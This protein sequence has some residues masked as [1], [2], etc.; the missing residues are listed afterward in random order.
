MKTMKVFTK[1]AV[2]ALSIA[3]VFAMTM[4]VL[5]AQA[6]MNWGSWV[7]VP[8]TGD[9]VADT[10]DVNGTTVSAVYNRALKASDSNYNSSAYSCAAFVG[11][12]YKVLGVSVYNLWTTSSVPLVSGVG[13]FYA[14]D[15]PNVGDIVRFNNSVHW[16]IVKYVSGTKATVIQQNAWGGN[17]T[18]AAVGAYVYAGD[19]DVTFFR[20]TTAPP[21]PV[22]QITP[23]DVRSTTEAYIEALLETGMNLSNAGYEL[24]LGGQDPV[25]R[26]EDANGAYV[27][28]IYYTLTGLQ[29]A[30]PYTYRL[31]VTTTDG[32]TY[33]SDPYFFFTQVD[34]YPSLSVAEVGDTFVRLTWTNVD[35]RTPANYEVRRSDGTILSCV[36][37][38]SGSWECTDVGLQPETEYTYSIR[39]IFWNG[40]TKETTAWS[41]TLLTVK[42]NETKP[43]IPAA[44]TLEVSSPHPEKVAM[45]LN[46]PE[47]A[48][49][50]ILVERTDLSTNDTVRFTIEGDGHCFIFYTDTNGLEAEHTYSY[51]ACAINK[52]NGQSYMGE[53][54][55]A[56]T[57][58]TL[59][60]HPDPSQPAFIEVGTDGVDVDRG[61]FYCLIPPQIVKK[62]GIRLN[63]PDGNVYEFTYLCGKDYFCEDA[64][65]AK[66][67][68]YLDYRL[69]SGKQ[70]IVFWYV[71]WQGV[72]HEAEP[73][74]FTTLQAAQKPTNFRAT[75]VTGSSVTLSWDPGSS[76]VS[77]YC[78]YRALNI[79][80]SAEYEAVA[81][82]SS[83][84]VSYTDTGLLDG[85]DYLYYLRVR[86]AH[87]A[88][89]ETDPITVTTT[90]LAKPADS[91]FESVYAQ[92]VTTTNAELIANISLTYLISGGFDF[93]T[94]PNQLTRISE[95]ANSK[96]LL[97]NY[98][99]NKWYGQL[100]PGTRYYYRIWYETTSGTVVSDLHSFYT[101][102]SAPVLQSVE[103]DGNSMKLTWKPNGNAIYYYIYRSEDGGEM[104]FY[105]CG[106]R[107]K[108]DTMSYN[109]T[110]VKR[111][112]QYNYQV[113]AVCGTRRDGVF[114]AVVTSAA[115]D[116]NTVAAPAFTY[117]ERPSNVTAAYADQK[118]TVS[119]TAG[120]KCDSYLIERSLSFSYTEPVGTVDG[121]TF[122]F[123]DT[124]AQPGNTYRYS[125][126]GICGSDQSM[127]TDSDYVDYPAPEATEIK[128]SAA[129]TVHCRVGDRLSAEYTVYPLLD[130]LQEVRWTSSAEDVV[131]VDG[132]GVLTANKEGTSRIT[133]IAT[134]G[135]G[136]SASFTLKVDGS[137]GVFKLPAALTTVESGAFAG[138]TQMTLLVLSDQPEL[139]V[140]SGA[141][142][143]CY[144]LS[145]IYAGPN[146]T[147]FQEDS[148][149]TQNRLTFCCARGSYAYQYAIRNGFNYLLMQ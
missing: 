51:R 67:G 90:S 47:V 72:T 145:T 36:E 112:V 99:L 133:A 139:T 97:M 88:I 105:V 95:T 123:T 5:S 138:N 147:S 127:S 52:A 26:T 109:D 50:S 146:A 27:K 48:P 94:D 60:W 82:P 77:E 121:S 28:K 43:L 110:N 73:Y 96:V 149:P 108:G 66:F 69:Q 85:M 56:V 14:V 75:A 120:E 4:G 41:S 104:K 87:D 81:Y 45:R 35:G 62:W 24:S 46:T 74:E 10:I 7:L 124:T 54:C 37:P 84:D 137:K 22:L 136:C 144:R 6:G 18:K 86:S 107:K 140:L 106:T 117:V 91:G 59:P 61:D 65:E 19:P 122:S 135:S 100:T 57:V 142:E 132:A 118:I 80:T 125:V 101:V 93:G 9:F 53:F 102:P 70:S 40:G 33:T 129:G 32:T 21:T 30:S 143:D 1:Y 114:D 89:A 11:K 63:E 111:G 17:Y 13:H 98:D 42:T 130:E 78:L 64:L 8:E 29:P 58:T 116:A 131:S 115:S 79:G 12:Y 20:Y 16:A 103:Q 92:S 31:F 49:D 71:D 128:L 3:M 83:A 119:W 134:D 25:R 148:F 15:T 39:Y 126:R 23:V 2:A 76:D 44:P 68:T 141:F 113:R 38:V 34:R 55:D